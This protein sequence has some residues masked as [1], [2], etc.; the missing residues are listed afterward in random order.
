V[1]SDLSF[2][3]LL[4]DSNRLAARLVEGFSPS[5][6]C[7]QILQVA[8]DGE[9]YGHHKKFGEL[10]LAHALTQALPQK[11][12][13]LCNY[14]AFLKL[15]PPHR[16]V[17]LYLGPSGAGSSW[18][19]AHGV[20]RWRSDCGCSTGGQPTWNQKWREPLRDAFDLLNERL[21]VLFESQGQKYFRDPWAARN[22]Y[23]QVILERTPE[24][25]ARFFSQEGTPNLNRSD[26]VP[27][28]MLLEMQRHALLMYTSCGWFFSDLA[29]LETLQVLKYA[30]RALQLGQN[31]TTDSLEPSFLQSLGRTVSNV[32]AAGTGQDLYVNRIKPLVVDF[33]KVVNQWAI[34]WLKDRHRLCPTNIY[35][36]RVDAQEVEDKVQGSLLLGAGRLQLTSGTTL[37]SRLLH[38]FTVYLGSYLY[39][40][41]IMES[42]SIQDF[43]SLK[44]KLFQVLEAA[45]ED[46]IAVMVRHLGERYYSFNDMFREEK[47]EIL[48]DLLSHNQ[49]EALTLISNNYEGARPLLK[50]MAGEGL[51][52]PRLYQAAGE[53]TLNHYLV[54]MLRKLE[55]EPDFSSIG[56]EILELV[57][58]AAVLGLKLESVRGG[59]ILGGIIDR[60][61]QDLAGGLTTENASRVKEFLT[62]MRR[63][64]ITVELTE[65]QNGFFALMEA[66]FPKLAARAAKDTG[67]RTLT[68]LLVELAEALFFS[69][70]RYLKLLS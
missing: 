46:L 4:Q 49:E 67:T 31:F 43:H 40:T 19:C 50:A 65:A 35:H 25:L 13:Q 34:T 68:R 37:K 27:A 11:G 12:F 17:E 28:L 10:A 38:F 36:F 14:A 66:H 8:T 33:P 32:P 56:E 63:I 52:L 22:A 64:P 45:P 9:N 70:V 26:W 23:I 21:G 48:Q 69:P 54:Q 55:I 7:H 47:N 44:E 57:Q 58:E 30:A 59:Q 1:A 24:T 61:L 18:S 51:P 2:G 60:H 20:E 15:A 16:E 39:R 5:R 29:G 6:G 62:L 53:I 42:Q 41:Q 3:D